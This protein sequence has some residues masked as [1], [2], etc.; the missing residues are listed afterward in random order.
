[1]KQESSMF[2]Q[3]DDRGKIFTRVIRKQKVHAVIQTN[4]QRI[5]GY[6]YIS[7]EDRLI[8]ELE[9]HDS[10]LPVTD[11]VIFNESGKKI[12]EAPFLAVQ[13]SQ[14]VWILPLDEEHHQEKP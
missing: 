13:I 12:Q 5:E 2:T 14:I 4:T 6:V 10:F 7:L 1:M 9:K 3:I 8:D 11:V